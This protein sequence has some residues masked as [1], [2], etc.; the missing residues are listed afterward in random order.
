MRDRFGPS[1]MSVAT[2]LSGL[3]DS[4]SGDRERIDATS[5]RVGADEVT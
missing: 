2:E 3:E 1:L 5:Q 4:L